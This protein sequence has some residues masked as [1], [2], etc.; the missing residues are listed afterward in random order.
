MTRSQRRARYR[1]TVQQRADGRFLQPGDLLHLTI[2]GLGAIEH[3]VVAED[4]A[5]AGGDG[6]VI[7]S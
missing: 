4:D 5:I 3:R 6:W 2:D 1:N 7:L